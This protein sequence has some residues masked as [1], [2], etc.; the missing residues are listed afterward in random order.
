MKNSNPNASG[1]LFTLAFFGLF[2]VA[3]IVVL[4]GDFEISSMFE[5]KVNS[6]IN[7]EVQSRISSVGTSAAK[8]GS[9]NNS[10]FYEL[11]GDK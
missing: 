1:V 2:F 11:T 6:A 4:A 5:D 3:M 10:L 7:T 8:T 9:I